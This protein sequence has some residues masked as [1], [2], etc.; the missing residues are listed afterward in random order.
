MRISRTALLILALVLSLAALGGVYV[1]NV[2][3]CV[4]QV[5][6]DCM[7]YCCSIGACPYPPGDGP[8]CQPTNPPS[9]CGRRCLC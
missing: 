6:S 7:A 9:S 2:S 8:Y 3:A 4:C 1:P 5:D